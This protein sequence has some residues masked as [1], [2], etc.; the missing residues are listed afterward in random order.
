LKGLEV[1]DRDSHVFQTQRLDRLEAK[2]VADDR[3][4]E[5]GDRTRLERVEVVG[6]GGEILLLGLGARPGVMRDVSGWFEKSVIEM[7][8][9]ETI[10][11]SVMAGLG[12]AFISGRTVASELETSRLALLNVLGMP[13]RR[14]WFEVAR[15]DR[16]KTPAMAAFDDFLSREG[17]RHLPLFSQLYADDIR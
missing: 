4:G 9:N 8:A 10:K 14:Q 1:G 12:V 6:D 7:D 3:S 5:V 16:A 13:I 15:S 17:A 2:D 11:Q